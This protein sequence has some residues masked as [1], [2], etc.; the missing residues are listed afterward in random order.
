MIMETQNKVKC[1]FCDKD[2]EFTQPEKQTGKI[3]DVCKTHFT[4]MYMG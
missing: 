4:F 1:T 2:A 3:I